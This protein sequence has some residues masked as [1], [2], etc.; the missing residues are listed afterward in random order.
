MHSASDH[1]DDLDQALYA[2]AV[3]MQRTAS[4]EAFVRATL[5][6]LRR[7][8]RLRNLL[9]VAVVLMAGAVA[10]ALPGARNLAEVWPQLQAAAAQDWL[11]ALPWLLVAGTVLA[12]APFLAADE[13][14]FAF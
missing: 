9:T 14:D 3:Q 2:W 4:D 8:E 10:M 5:L 11:H 7:R 1:L 13:L 6:R 12:V